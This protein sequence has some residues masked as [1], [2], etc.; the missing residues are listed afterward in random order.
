MSKFGSPFMAKSPLKQ[1]GKDELKNVSEL[2]GY[3]PI[4]SSSVN[5]PGRG[6]ALAKAAAIAIPAS[7]PLTWNMHKTVDKWNQEVWDPATEYINESVIPKVKEFKAK[8]STK[9]RKAVGMGPHIPK[10]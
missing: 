10:R 2:P 3:K 5:V 8:A 7:I 1:N 4:I 9:I 6:K